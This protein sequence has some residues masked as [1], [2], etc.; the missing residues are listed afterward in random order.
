MLS[1]KAWRGCGTGMMEG[2]M[3]ESVRKR[4]VK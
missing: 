2:V 1:V 4:V 3:H